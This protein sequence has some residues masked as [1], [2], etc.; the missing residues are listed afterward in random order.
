LREVPLCSFFFL[1]EKPS[2]STSDRLLRCTRLDLLGRG[3]NLFPTFAGFL[4]CISLFSLVVE[5]YA[6]SVNRVSKAGAFFCANSTSHLCTSSYLFEVLSSFCFSIRPF[7]RP[8]I[9]EDRNSISAHPF[10]CS[11]RRSFPNFLRCHSGIR[12]AGA[13]PAE[14]LTSSKRANKSVPFCHFFLD[15]EL[16]VFH[17]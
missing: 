12:V 4:L 2:L 8:A 14:L 7:F 9:H 1:V 13:A 16:D 6:S 10:R 15:N 5:L 11:D 17:N 3:P